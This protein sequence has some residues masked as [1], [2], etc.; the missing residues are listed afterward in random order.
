MLR[1]SVCI[2]QVISETM[3]RVSKK[4]GTMLLTLFY[5]M[6]RYFFTEALGYQSRTVLN[7]FSNIVIVIYKGCDN[8][9]VCVFF[10]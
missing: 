8:L 4:Y 7:M 10:F 3:Y 5:F 1:Y 9:C 2:V 6:K